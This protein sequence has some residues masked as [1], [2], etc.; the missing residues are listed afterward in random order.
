MEA[1]DP[2]NLEAFAKLALD[3]A[4]SGNAWMLISLA[5][6][7]AVYLVRKFL[8]PKVPFLRTQGGG[9]ILNLVMAFAG[10]L[11]STLLAG[12]TMSPLLA[13]AAFKVAFT[14]AGGWTLVKH[15]LSLVRVDPEAI[16]AAAEAE[17]V[18]AKDAAVAAGKVLSIEEALKEKKP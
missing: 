15:L 1:L 18:K 6:I 11:A 10:A 17:G 9:A 3:A 12:Q 5:L 13:L 4:R 8:G 14:A 2:E 7:L 16:K